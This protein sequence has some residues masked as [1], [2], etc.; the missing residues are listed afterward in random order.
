MNKVISL[1][2][3]QV[4][5][6]RV[7]ASGVSK[8]GRAY[9]SKLLG[10]INVS[11]FTERD[12]KTFLPALW[13][14][15]NLSPE[16]LEEHADFIFKKVMF[17]GSCIPVCSAEEV[18]LACEALNILK[19]KCDLL[20]TVMTGELTISEVAL[21]Q[22]Q[23]QNFAE[24]MSRVYIQVLKNKGEYPGL[25]EYENKLG[26]K[27]N[28]VGVETFIQIVLQQSRAR[29]ETLREGSGFL[30]NHE[31]AVLNIFSLLSVESI[32]LLERFI[33]KELYSIESFRVNNFTYIIKM[34]PFMGLYKKPGWL[35]FLEGSRTARAPSLLELECLSS[36]LAKVD[37]KKGAEVKKVLE[38][39]F[40]E[41]TR[42]RFIKFSLVESALALDPE[43]TL[44]QAH[45]DFADYMDVSL[46]YRSYQKWRRERN[47]N[48]YWKK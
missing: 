32:S 4:A 48:N 14:L 17:D 27:L 46:F 23:K 28:A 33:E 35:D 38:S 40:G 41:K 44:Y 25:I 34:F 42:H 11:Q 45:K 10:L 13:A 26:A 43:Y 7:H 8:K 20:V 39:A 2:E 37:K 5:H 21:P 15:E 16:Q 30:T 18:L 1:K 22:A 3:M 19:S 6:D 12:L 9:T 36:T 47:I 29:Y 24:R 31:L